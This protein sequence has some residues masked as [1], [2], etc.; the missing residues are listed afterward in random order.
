MR[1]ITKRTLAISTAA[2]IAIGGG[3]AAWAWSL[4]GEGD[5]TA[6]AESAQNLTITGVSVT[7][8]APGLSVPVNFTAGNKNRYQVRISGATLTNLTVDGA[9][10]GCVPGT[11]VVLNTADMEHATGTTIGAGDG[12]RTY[13]QSVSIPHA[14]SMSQDASDACKEAT[15][16]LHV[17]VNATTSL[18]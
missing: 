2:A 15:F 9:H 6:H 12:T 13:D 16:T 17:L 14:I 7:G 11:D 8:L 18:T 1:K 5:T 10:S 4:S 3:A